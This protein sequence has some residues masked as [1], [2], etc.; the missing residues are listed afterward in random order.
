MTKKQQ[1]LAESTYQ[2][3]KSARLPLN[4]QLF[5]EETPGETDT[6]TGE[7]TNTDENLVEEETKPTFDELLK[8]KA[9]QS[10][11]D[12]RVAQSIATA[13]KRWQE[14]AA[15]EADEA[16]KLEKMSADERE[17]YQL[18]QEKAT[19]EKERQKFQKEQLKTAVAS[20]LLQRGYTAE[21]AD[22]L[23][24]N[25]AE[26][27]KANIEAFEVVFKKAVENAT[28]KAMRGQG[29]PLGA[30]DPSTNAPPTDYHAYEAWR[31]ENS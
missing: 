7:D 25:D 3:V 20:E 30:K 1:I 9:F 12:Q 21:F 15:N 27:S 13:K 11:Y 8:D 23:T 26:S 28:A 31:N 29:V 19:F 18:K 5:A 14:N 24:S 17:R 4:I 2:T 10:E 16:K 22:F 6:N